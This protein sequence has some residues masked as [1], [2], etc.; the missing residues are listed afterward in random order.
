MNNLGEIIKEKDNAPKPPAT[1]CKRCLENVEPKF[2]SLLGWRGQDYCDPCAEIIAE[3]R[4]REQEK[5]SRQER[6]AT[7]LKSSG[8]RGIMHGM[9]FESF[10]SERGGKA[11]DIAKKY[12]DDFGKETTKGLM[13]YGRAGSGKTHLATAIAKLLIEQKQIPVLFARVVDLL[14]DIRR[15]FDE[16]EQYRTDNETELLRKCTSVPLFILDDLGAEKMTD[17]VRQVLYQIIDERWINQKPMIVTSNLSL[18]ELEGRLE[19]RIASRI[20]GMCQLVEMRDYDYR[21]IK[22]TP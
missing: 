7:L 14:S 4:E 22:P 17:W 12:A 3:A 8:L 15:T 2:I 21:I 5:L 18:E 6:M 9:T 16:N 10:D 20:A 19:E 1:R 11:Y 13:L